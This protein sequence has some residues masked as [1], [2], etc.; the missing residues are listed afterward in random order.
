MLP[1]EGK[2]MRATLPSPLFATAKPACPPAFFSIYS[3]L[4]TT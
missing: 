4:Y 3:T 2:P 1:T